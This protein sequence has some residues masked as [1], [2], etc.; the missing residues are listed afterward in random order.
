MGKLIISGLRASKGRL[1]LTVLAV[2][3]GVSFV[4]G[5][6]V[7]ADSLRAIFDQVSEDAFAGVDAQVQSIPPDL[8][9]GENF[10]RFDAALVDDV[11][12]LPEVE[13]AEGG[14]FVFEQVYTVGADGEVN[15]PTGPPVFTSSWGGP[16][17]VSAFTLVDGEPPVGQQVAL[18][19][20]Q[21]EAGGFSIGDDITL[22]LPTG[23]PETFELTGI[24][25]FGQGGTGGAY[26]IL[27]DLPTTQRVLGIGNEIDSIVVNA[28]DGVETADLLA[29]IETVIPAGIEVLSGE[30]VIADQQAEFGEFI[31][32]FGNILLGFALVTLFV[33]TFIIY[34]TFAI[35]VTQR[36]RELGLLRAIGASGPQIRAIVL[37]E[38]LIVA[39][40][41]SIFGLL[42]G[43]GVASALKWLFSQGGGEFPE[44]PLQILPRTIIV[45]FAV[46]IVVTV[47]SALVPS[48]RASRVSPLE[49][50]REGGEVRRSMRFRLIAGSAVLVPGVVLLGLGLF[51]G[52]DSTAGV[53]TLLGLG[54]ALTFIGVAMVSALF[55]SRVASLIGA[56]IDRLRGIVGHLA[57]QNASRNPQ[58]TTATATA[59][60]IGLALITGVAVLTESIRT[61]FTAVLDETVD[62]DLFIFEENQGLGFSP[63][64]IDQLG[65]LPEVGASVGFGV[66]ETRIDGVVED[67]ATVTTDQVDA[68]VDLGVLEGSTALGTDGI[69]V[70]ADK[71]TELALAVGDTVAIELEDGFTTDLTVKAIFDDATFFNGSNWFIDRALASPHISTDLVGTVAVTYVD[72]IDAATGRAAVDEALTAFPQL[73]SQDNAEFKE[74]LQS[75]IN[76]LLVIIGGLLLVCV[77]VAFFGIVNTMAL[78]V[79]ERTREIGLL[80]AVG[81]TRPQLKSSVRW[82]SVIVSLFGSLLG[83]VM[84]MLLG[85]AAVV[86]VP[87]SF[88]SSVSIPWNLIVIFLLTG[89][90]LGVV[91]AAFPARRAS[92]LN[93]LAAIAGAE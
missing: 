83:V 64:V 92:R 76:Q 93:V 82:E 69:A 50:I 67:T 60:M 62:A 84:G 5:A 47:L 78:A 18:D 56:P 52:A 9:S 22:S 61:S 28:A 4:S 40:V 2:F 89:G 20:A 58:R 1:A 63:T 71:A 25:D 36:T 30:D 48:F 45:T 42:G 65:A 46:G 53:L 37:V 77:I 19:K 73:S 79:L 15:R 24:I 14:I 16:S 55:A 3:L 86:A 90:V 68:V 17:A 10:V 57:R 43:L 27:L 23:E 75:Q 32:I 7:L 87:D 54:S 38:A 70:Y 31:D 91:A 59:L 74:T 8:S 85:W 6:F 33:A 39:V 66:I 88:I 12:A 44:G 21:A 35:L 13:F 51:G 11:R 41:A 29:S 80:R 72:G 34:N 49:A 81:M 26:F